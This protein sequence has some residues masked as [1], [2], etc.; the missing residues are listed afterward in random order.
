MNHF[1]C[2]LTF[3]FITFNKMVRLK[4]IYY[5]PGL[6]SAILIPLLFWY[7]I[8]PYVN[9]TRTNVVDVW[10][11]SKIEKGNRKEMGS[12]VPSERINF[13]KITVPPNRAKQNSKFYVSEIKKLKERDN[14]EKGIEFILDD[15]NFYGDFASLLNDLSIAQVDTYG[16]DLNKTGHIFVTY[17][18]PVVENRSEESLLTDDHMVIFEDPSS[19]NIMLYEIREFMTRIYYNEFYN[20]IA[21]LPKSTYYIIF[22]FLFLLNIS[23]LSI[24]ENF[25][26]NRS[27]FKYIN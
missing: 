25:Q 3:I 14:K 9:Y 8:S 13:I 24:K 19:E 11:P 1:F 5:V 21:K 16:F 4:K 7:Y 27:P 17:S 22:G 18:P 12:L 10:L 2:F 15:I 26:I 20:D 6:I 23:M